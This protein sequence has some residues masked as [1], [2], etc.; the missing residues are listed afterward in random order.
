VATVIDLFFRRVVGWSMSATMTA[1][2]VTDGLVMA[3][4]RI[5]KPDALLHDSDR[6]SQYTSE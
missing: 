1:H 2:L 4:W 3:I 5:G 6:G